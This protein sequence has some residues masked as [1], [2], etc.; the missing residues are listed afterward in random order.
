M[1]LSWTVNSKISWLNNLA[2]KHVPGENMPQTTVV[3]TKYDPHYFSITVH[4]EL[5]TV[6]H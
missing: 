1:R 5:F 3:N 6:K 4:K 2:N